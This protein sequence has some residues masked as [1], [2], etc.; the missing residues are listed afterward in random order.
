MLLQS[1]WQAM[2]IFEASM[3]PWG[4]HCLKTDSFLNSFGYFYQVLAVKKI[5]QL[6][7]IFGGQ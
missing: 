4:R 2:F 1:V 7:V 6:S 3:I 5:Q